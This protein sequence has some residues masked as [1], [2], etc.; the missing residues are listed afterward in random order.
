MSAR[1]PVPGAGSPRVAM[2]NVLDA[3]PTP[4]DWVIELARACDAPG[5]SQASVARRI[6][7]SASAVSSVLRNSYGGDL[8]RVEQVVR[9]ALMAETVACPIVGE[10]TRNVCLGHQ[11]RARKFVPTSSMRVHLYRTC[12]TC[13]HSRMK[14]GEPHA[15]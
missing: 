14:G 9:G 7:Y 3:W 5:A 10:I 15:E 13:P 11:K 2:A 6:D 1:G 8:A 12:P 4:P